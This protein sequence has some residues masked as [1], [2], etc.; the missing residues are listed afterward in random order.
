[1]SGHSKWATIKRKKA[2]VDAA[3]G[4]TFTKL[5]KEITIAARAGG[6]DPEGNPRLKT[7]ILTAKAANMPQD[8]IKKAIQKGTG[9]LPGVSYEDATFEGYGPG[10]VAVFVDALTDNRNR[11]VA[12]I[13]HI[14]SKYNGN[15]GEN[16]CVAWM[17]EKKGV[18]TVSKDNA[19]EDHLMDVALDAGAADIDAQE[20]AFEITAEPGNLEQVRE[21][22]EKASFNIMEAEIRRVPQNTV[23]LDR[24][25]AESMMKLYDALDEHDDVQKVSANFDIDDSIL[26]ELSA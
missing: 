21:N 16:G 25:G 6:G 22:L 10:G 1:M 26:E 15:L 4:R 18:I 3:R 20:D 2:K 19:D 8:N 24:K 9:E 13:R 14:F 11:T 12:E 7:A 5:I 23:T 17:F